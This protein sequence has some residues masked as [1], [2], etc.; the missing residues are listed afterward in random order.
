MKFREQLIIDGLR[1]DAALANADIAGTYDVDWYKRA[2]FAYNAK[3][4]TS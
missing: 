3:G 1:K 4:F 2:T